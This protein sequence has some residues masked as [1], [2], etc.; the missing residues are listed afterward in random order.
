MKDTKHE[1]KVFLVLKCR[2][3]GR[4]YEAL[5]QSGNTEMDYMRTLSLGVP[6]LHL[7]R[8]DRTGVSDLIGLRV[9]NKKVAKCKSA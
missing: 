6:G 8:F 2:L 5:G 9:A 7:C 3:C 4:K 1:Q